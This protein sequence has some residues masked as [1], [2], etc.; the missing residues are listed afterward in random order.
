VLQVPL[1]AYALARKY[2]G[3]HA[4][5]VE[6]RALKKPEAVHMLE[7]YSI[8]GPGRS[9]AP[10]DKAADKLETALDAVVRSVRAARSGAFPVAPAPSCK[11][12][13]F[14]HS[15]EICRVPGGPDTGG[16]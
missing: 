13:S 4:V 6:Y 7:L 9:P 15:L 10:D 12:P 2:P 8:A 3:T 1:Y 14:C 16:W 11:C 5:R